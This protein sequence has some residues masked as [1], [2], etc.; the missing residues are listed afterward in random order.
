MTVDILGEKTECSIVRSK[1]RTAAIE[2][3]NGGIILRLPYFVPRS[4]GLAFVSSRQQWIAR[5]LSEQRKAA[6]LF[7]EPDEQLE[8]ELRE[9][10]KL[11]IKEKVERYS[12]IMGVRCTGIKITGAKTRFGSC[13]AKNSLCF[14]WRLMLRPPEAVDCV[15][16]HELAHIAHKNHGRAFYALMAS[17][18]PDYKE[19]QKLL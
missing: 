16:V 14:S 11:I 12:S 9:K 18:L 6:A 7:P 8:K 17:V 19:R 2:V 4:A 3:K 15:V 1:R 5:R 13:S 10:A